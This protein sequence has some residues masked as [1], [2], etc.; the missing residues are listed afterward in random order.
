MKNFLK[1]PN[2]KWTYLLAVVVVMALLFFFGWLVRFYERRDLS[3]QQAKEGI[4]VQVMR[5]HPEAKP[6]PL[7]LPSFLEALNSTPIFARVNGYLMNFY[8]DIG[9][10]VTTGQLLADIDTP[11]LDAQVRE[12]FAN[13]KSYLAEEWIARITA[14]RWCRLF[15]RNPEAISREEVDEKNAI[16]E[17]SIANTKAAQ[18]HFNYLEALQEFKSVYAP[19]SGVITTRNIDIGSLITAG[20]EPFAEPLFQI[21]NFDWLRAFVD[22][23]QP[24][25]TYIQDGVEASISVPQFPGKVFFGTILRNASALAP[26]AR[27]LR[28]QISI[29]NR[30]RLLLPGLYAE[31]RFSF[32]PSKEH[33]IIPI[34]ALIIRNGPP[35]VAIVQKE[36]RVHLQQ[37]EIGRDL[38]NQIEIIAGLQD[39]DLLVLNPNYQISEGVQVVVRPEG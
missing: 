19:F 17:A 3:F 29:D 37:V 5:A 10:T 35:Y 12:A 14:E 39:G 36:G 26:I 22:V 38:G 11:E 15:E 34:D 30:E 24:F 6:L 32:T 20:S 28:A 2:R 33:F 7:T 4:V 16:W 23:P 18:E 1:P 21:A 31:V 25:F 13:Y 8:V 27:T 9:D